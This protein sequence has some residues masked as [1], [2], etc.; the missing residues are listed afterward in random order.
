MWFQIAY[1]LITVPILQN[2]TLSVLCGAEPLYME[3][4]ALSQQIY[5]SVLISLQAVESCYPR[6][7]PNNLELDE[8]ILGLL[9]I[10]RRTRKCVISRNVDGNSDQGKRQ[11]NNGHRLDI[12]KTFHNQ[13]VD[14]M[15][16]WLNVRQVGQLKALESYWSSD[17]YKLHA[18]VQGDNL[19]CVMYT[20]ALPIHTMRMISKET[21]QAV[22]EERDLCF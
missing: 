9:L 6:N 4:Q 17:Y 15:D 19:I 7:I 11:L 5:A 20:A 22:M 2:V 3:V 13:A 1:R 10:N 16:E 12:L 21:L 14:M 18:L 8:G